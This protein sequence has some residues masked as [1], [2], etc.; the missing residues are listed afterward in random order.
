MDSVTDELRH[1]IGLSGRVRASGSPV[2]R[3]RV[4]VTQAIK[5][6]LRVIADNDARFGHYLTTTIKTGTY[7]SYNPDPHFAVSWLL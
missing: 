2:E 3:A 6:A 5:A 1:G 7:C 4:S